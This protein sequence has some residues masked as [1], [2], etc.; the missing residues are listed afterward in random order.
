VG[1]DFA[2][3][4][5]GRDFDAACVLDISARPFVQVCELHGH[6]GERFDRV[7]YAVLRA[8]G[9]AFLL[10][11][12]QVGL[13]TLRRLYREYEHRVMYYQRDEDK[14][15]SPVTDRL[16]WPRVAN[17][18]TTREFRRAVM[19]RQVIIRSRPTIDQMRRTVWYS[20]RERTAG[21]DRSR[22]EQLQI[23]LN[24]G[25]SPDLVIAAMYAYYGAAFEQVHFPKP[26]E[27]YAPNTLGAIFGWNEREGRNKAVVSFKGAPKAST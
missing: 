19:D 17:D 18:I 10:G 23:K 1:A 20:Q 13:P 21:A 4:I 22:D 26:P 7:L 15:S 24:G 2:Y 25:G 3:G 6:W 12:R 14:K 9:D 11:E 5:E 8:Y 27:P 16:G